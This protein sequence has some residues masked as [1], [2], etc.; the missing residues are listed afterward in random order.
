MTIKSKIPNVTYTIKTSVSYD[1]KGTHHGIYMYYYGKMLKPMN[2]YVDNAKTHIYNCGKYNTIFLIDEI[3]YIDGIDTKCIIKDIVGVLYY[4]LY[5]CSKH[6]SRI[7]NRI[8]AF[9]KYLLR[10]YEAKWT[11]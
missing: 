3:S 8:N 1:G 4:A 10:F 7:T 2:F 9:E 6:S 5:F 11:W